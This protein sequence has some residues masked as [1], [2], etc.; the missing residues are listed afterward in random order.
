MFVFG[1]FEV[2]I[3][4]SVG[5]GYGNYKLN[6][7]SIFNPLELINNGQI[8]WSNILPSIEMSSGEQS[9]G[10]NYLGLGGILLLLILIITSIFRFKDLNFYK[11][12][13]FILI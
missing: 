9:E 12:K 7:A 8:L 3:T 4:D 5:V 11:L 13:P 2:P 10:F 1:Y 6:L